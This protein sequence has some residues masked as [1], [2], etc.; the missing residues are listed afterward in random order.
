MLRTAAKAPRP[1]IAILADFPWGYFED[2]ATGRG[3]G[4]AAT[5]LTQLAELFAKEDRFEFHWITLDRRGAPSATREWHGQHFHRI[6]AGKLSIDLLLGYRLAKHRLL[7]VIRKIGPDLVHCWGSESAYPIVCASLNVPTIFSMQGILTHLAREGLVPSIWQWKLIAAWEPR[8]L[9]TATVITAESQWG[10]DIIREL[11]P[12]ADVRQV[13]YGVDPSF[14]KVEWRPDEVEPYALFVGYAGYGKG[15]DL[16]C[17]AL[18]RLGDRQWKLKVVGEGPYQE[19]FNDGLLPKTEALGTMRWEDLQRQ[20]AGARCLVLPTR[21][22]TSPNVVK[23][24]RVIGLPVVTSSRGGQSGYILD[25]VNGFIVE[26]L[27]AESLAGVLDRLMNDPQLARE[28]G[29]AR[30]EEDRSYFL[31]ARTAE[32]FLTLYDELLA[33]AR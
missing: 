32:G 2:G 33:V 1:K 25:G 5:W 21:G 20:L 26:P 29:A 23:E 24:A 10:A 27:D 28:M 4:Q 6:A 16:L 19:R 11:Q 8:F 3:G 30:H 31:P 13:E 22:D 9:S 14:Y 17:D 12:G 18:A 15:A 7:S